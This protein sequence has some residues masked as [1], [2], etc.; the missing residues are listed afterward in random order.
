MLTS[1]PNITAL[2]QSIAGEYLGL[3]NRVVLSRS[4]APLLTFPSPVDT[5]R[6]Q[7]RS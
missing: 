5:S 4:V 6:V 2:F 1:R 7:V 3:G